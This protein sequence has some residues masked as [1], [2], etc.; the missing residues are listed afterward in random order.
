MNFVFL[1]DHT[2]RTMHIETFIKIKQYTHDSLC[3]D[4]LWLYRKFVMDS[5]DV[6]IH[7][8]KGYF[9]V[10]G[11]IV[12]SGANKV[13][14]KYV[15]TIN[16]WWR[17]QME[18]FSALLGICAGNSSVTGEFLAQRPVTRS[19]D[20]S[21]DLYLNKRVSKQWQGWWFETPSCPLWRHCN[22]ILNHRKH[23]KARIVCTILG[24]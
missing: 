12:S 18:T 23:N 13:T 4:F 14:L 19:F 17:H 6:F 22:A 5:C 2:K 9:S 3:Y 7:I 10:T 15:V 8:I 16:P 21:F 11:P 1:I 24:M 20:V